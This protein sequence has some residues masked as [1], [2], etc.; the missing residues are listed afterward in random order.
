[1]LPV[2]YNISPLSARVITFTVQHYASAVY[3]MALC[4]VV[5]LL[6]NRWWIPIGLKGR[7]SSPRGESKDGILHR[8]PGVFQH[9]RHSVWLLWHLNSVWHLQHLSAPSVDKYK[10]QNDREGLNFLTNINHREKYSNTNCE[11]WWIPAKTCRISIVR[12]RYMICI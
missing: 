4:L 1:M 5:K 8:R 10:W 6:S 3:A 9:S 7:S 2:L 12:Y 11:E